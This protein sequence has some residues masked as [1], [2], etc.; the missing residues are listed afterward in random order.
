MLAVEYGLKITQGTRTLEAVGANSTVAEVLQVPIGSPLMHI[1][2]ISYEAG[3]RALELS[4]SYH[5]GNRARF[6]FEL[7]QN[8][9][10][11]STGG[12]QV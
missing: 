2:L 9:A 10:M 3:G 5:R 11:L 4:E 8:A 1:D 12:D 6:R 7:V